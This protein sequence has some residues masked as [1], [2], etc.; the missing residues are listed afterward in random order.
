ML[1]LWFSKLLHQ[2]NLPTS[3][4]HWNIPASALPTLAE[5]ALAQWTANFNPVPVNLPALQRLYQQT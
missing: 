2:A 1:P 3:L 5:Q 4:Q